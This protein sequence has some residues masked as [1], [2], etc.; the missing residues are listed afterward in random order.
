MS[1]RP[2]RRCGLRRVLADRSRLM[3]DEPG[4]AWICSIVPLANP[5]GFASCCDRRRLRLIAVGYVRSSGRW[6]RTTTSRRSRTPSLRWTAGSCVTHGSATL[7]PATWVLVHRPLRR[8]VAGGRVLPLSAA[9]IEAT[10]AGRPRLEG[11]AAGACGAA[12]DGS[13]VNVTAS[14]RERVN[15]GRKA[16]LDGRPGCLDKRCRVMARVLRRAAAD[17]VLGARLCGRVGV[18]VPGRPRQRRSVSAM[19]PAEPPVHQ[20]QATTRS[21]I[22]QPAL[23]CTTTS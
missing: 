18:G 11:V 6:L 5:R 2:T 15:F 16:N 13:S 14:D 19:A 1:S 10:A 3:L 9:S 7:V 8:A 17:R 22:R 4:C 20:R 21:W 12:G 23:V